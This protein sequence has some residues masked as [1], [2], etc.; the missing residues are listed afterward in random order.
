M[1][2]SGRVK[3]GE[4]VRV[5]PAAVLRTGYPARKT[6]LSLCPSRSARVLS[7][8]S[9]GERCSLSLRTPGEPHLHQSSAGRDREQ[10]RTSDGPYHQSV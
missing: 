9:G 6:H 3:R 5:G 4:E 7:S 8:H 10:K 1:S 2:G